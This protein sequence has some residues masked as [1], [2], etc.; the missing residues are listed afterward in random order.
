ML[1]DKLKKYPAHYIRRIQQISNAL[2]ARECGAFDLTAVQYAALV[3]MQRFP[4]SDQSTIASSIGYDKVTMGKVLE[5]LEARGFLVR[6]PDPENRRAKLT[7]IT[8][9]GAELIDTVKP[10]VD[11]LNEELVSPLTQAEQAEFMRMLQK[12]VEAHNESSR[13]PV[14]VGKS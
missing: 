4:N 11:R 9:R 6:T 13:A 10:R 8:P 5:K 12:I 2:F 1:I 7:N 3:A 14:R